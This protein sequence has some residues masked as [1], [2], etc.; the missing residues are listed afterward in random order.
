[1]LPRLFSIQSQWVETW[2]R[3]WHWDVWLTP[4]LLLNTPGPGE[5]Q[6]RW[7]P[8]FKFLKSSQIIVLSQPRLVNDLTRISD[9]QFKFSPLALA[10][11]ACGASVVLGWLSRFKFCHPIVRSLRLVNMA[12]ERMK[13]S[14]A[15]KYGSLNLN[16]ERWYLLQHN[17]VLFWIFG[18]EII[19][20]N[21]YLTWPHQSSLNRTVVCNIYKYFT[22]SN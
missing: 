4:I 2:V 14:I 15:L 9:Y 20:I 13:I 18:L 6:D 8:Q 22:I 16:T 5:T 17:L 19:S 1:M 10:C 12:K 7:V 11:L 21:I 3:V